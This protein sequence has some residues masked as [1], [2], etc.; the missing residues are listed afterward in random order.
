MTHVMAPD[1]RRRRLTSGADLHASE[2]YE[3][4]EDRR[5][6]VAASRAWNRLL[7]DVNAFNYI[8]QKKSEERLLYMLQ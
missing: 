1:E 4:M 5:P 7:T 3:V 8:F 2:R 6:G